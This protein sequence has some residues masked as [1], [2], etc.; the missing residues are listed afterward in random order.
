MLRGFVLAS[1]ATLPLERRQS[2]TLKPFSNIEQTCRVRQQRIAKTRHIIGGRSTQIPGSRR[3]GS[4]WEADSQG[5]T[6]WA[7]GLGRRGFN[8]K[9]P[10][11]FLRKRASGG[12]LERVFM[13]L[14]GFPC[15]AVLLSLYLQ[16][17]YGS[18]AFGA[19]LE[20]GGVFFL[21][22]AVP[23]LIC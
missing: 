19:V 7:Q 23:G 20:C 22:L 14:W 18:R 8:F 2:Q 16:E 11:N 15:I 12:R 13:L 4:R 5:C 1:L 21:S 9:C 6:S 17:G 3:C 10:A